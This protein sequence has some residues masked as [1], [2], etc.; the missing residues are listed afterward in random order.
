MN[1]GDMKIQLHIRHGRHC[2]ATGALALDTSE[3]ACYVIP[4]LIFVRACCAGKDELYLIKQSVCV[5]NSKA[6][7][8]QRCYWERDQN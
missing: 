7:S 1:I 2:M 6:A 4:T 8:F 5:E 3:Q